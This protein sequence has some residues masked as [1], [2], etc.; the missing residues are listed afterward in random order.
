MSLNLDC[1]CEQCNA[2]RK[3]GAITEL[4]ALDKVDKRLVGTANY[5]RN[6]ISELVGLN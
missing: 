1:E 6:R 5:I 2:L 4:K 3:Q